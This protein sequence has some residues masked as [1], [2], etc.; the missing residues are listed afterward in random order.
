MASIMAV[1]LFYFIEIGSC[2]FGAHCVT[3]VEGI[4][5]LSATEM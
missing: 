2:N 3:A 5:K 4:P 1:I